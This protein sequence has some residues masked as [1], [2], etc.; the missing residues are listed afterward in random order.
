MLLFLQHRALHF[1]LWCAAALVHCGGTLE[2]YYKKW[3]WNTP[4]HVRYV[5]MGYSNV[6]VMPRV[7]ATSMCKPLPIL[8]K[9]PWVSF[10]NI[11]WIKEGWKEV[12]KCWTTYSVF[13]RSAHSSLNWNPALVISEA[14]SHIFLVKQHPRYMCWGQG[15]SK[16]KHM[17]LM[18]GIM[19]T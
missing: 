14:Q 13:L 3:Q 19:E 17:Q 16:N 8:K 12:S 9:W 1:V 11:Q 7:T 2:C 4:N 6:C 5:T 10:K 15:H 18:I